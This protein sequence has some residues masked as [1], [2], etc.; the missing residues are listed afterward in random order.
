MNNL[1]F[2]R[3]IFCRAQ[4]ASDFT[5]FGLELFRT[6]LGYLLAKGEMFRNR[7]GFGEVGTKGLDASGELHFPCRCAVGVLPHVEERET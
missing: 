3:E 2:R 7:I 5:Y 1:V 6:H 4:Q